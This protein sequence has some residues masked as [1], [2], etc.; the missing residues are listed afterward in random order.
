MW[1]LERATVSTALSLLSSGPLK[2]KCSV[3]EK[4]SGLH[5]ILRLHTGK[6]DEEV[7]KILLDQEIRISARSD[8]SPFSRHTARFFSSVTP[9]WTWLSSQGPWRFFQ[10]TYRLLQL[11]LILTLSFSL[12][13]APAATMHSMV[14]VSFPIT[15]IR[16]FAS[17]RTETMAAEERPS[18]MAERT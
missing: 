17:L 18:K 11:F 12:H 10:R 7:K 9:I 13:F 16:D 8:F 6:E 2:E 14:T 5:F 3:I 15:A 4:E 1:P